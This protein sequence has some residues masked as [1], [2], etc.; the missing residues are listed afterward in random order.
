M[1]RQVKKSAGNCSAES[2]QSAIYPHFLPAQWSE[3]VEWAYLPGDSRV[4]LKQHEEGNTRVGV[5]HAEQQADGVQHLV[6]DD[7]PPTCCP[8]LGGTL[9]VR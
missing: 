3:P 1:S 6:D 5:D 9:R 8:Y 4:D 2:I 7:A